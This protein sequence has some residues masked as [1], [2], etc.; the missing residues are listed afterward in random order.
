MK[1]RLVI[2]M[3]AT[4][5][6]VLL[7]FA[8]AQADEKINPYRREMLKA[9]QDA[10]RRMSTDS[11]ASVYDAD[12]SISISPSQP[13]PGDTVVFWV[14]GVSNA[15][16]QDFVWLLI[17]KRDNRTN[18][19]SG[20]LPDNQRRGMSSF[21]YK[22]YYAGTYYC[23]VSVNNHDYAG[24]TFTIE[25]DGSVTLEEKCKQ[26]ADACKGSTQWQTALNLYDWL[27]ENT[28]YDST[29]QYYGADMI[30]S[31]YGVCDGYAKA[32]MLLCQA[33]GI[34]I[35]RVE[36]PDHAWNA[37]VLGGKWYQADS[38]WDSGHSYPPGQGTKKDGSEGHTYF[39]LSSEIMQSI[40]AHSVSTGPHAYECK[41]LAANY[42][43]HQNLW[44]AWG[45]YYWAYEGGNYVLRTNKWIDQ[46]LNA[47]GQGTT[48]F[49]FSANAAYHDVNGKAEYVMG[50]SKIVDGILCY[51][52]ARTSLVLYGDR[53]KM[54]AKSN[55]S[56]VITA[57][58]KGWD[59]TETGT[60]KLPASLKNVPAN[61]FEKTA[62]TT[63]I[64]PTGCTS[65]G[66]YAFTYSG[67]RTITIP[68]SVN[69]ISPDAFYGCGK[70]IV[71]TEAG[72][73]AEGYASQHDMIVIQP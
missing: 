69:W 62:S 64:I 42:Y 41:D 52:L 44:Q 11:E 60:L 20:R 39:C 3:I 31:G 61:G 1:K 12:I 57:K 50:S 67:V 22:F 9:Q 23:Q 24:F 15:N 68:S 17:D 5:C 70:I 46:I 21:Q 36:N 53:I 33:A 49:E 10:L 45:D 51:G 58:L 55:S 63:V 27:T 32:Y 72:S 47:F 29:L 59:L 65:I 8:S 4:A 56:H 25:N 19:Y 18:Y 30:F 14:N 2:V 73:Y 54:S 35:E 28:Y 43:I 71:K 13:K 37:L 7:L 34:T 26:I 66:S 16:S 38:T 6:F 40:D 48:I